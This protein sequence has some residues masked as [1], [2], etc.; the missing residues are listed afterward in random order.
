M[1]L[2]VA[3]Y[4]LAL[5]NWTILPEDHLWHIWLEK[6][7]GGYWFLLLL[8]STGRSTLV[9]FLYNLAL[10]KGILLSRIP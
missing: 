2:L 4:T 8:L 10:P 6:K 9:G 3:H 7:P 1:H 5:T